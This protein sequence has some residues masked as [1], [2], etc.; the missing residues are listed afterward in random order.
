M[1]SQ[2]EAYLSPAVLANKNSIARTI[3]TISVILL[4]ASVLAGVVTAFD[5]NWDAAR[6]LAILILPLIATLWLSR[7]GQAS[8]AVF[9]LA[10]SLLM[11]STILATLGQGIHDVTN[12]VYPGI[13]LVSS[14]V[15]NKRAFFM[16]TALAL[17]AIG[18]LVLGAMFGLFAPRPHAVGALSDLLIVSVILITTAFCVYLLSDNLQQ[19]LRQANEQMLER[20]QAERALRESQTRLQLIFDHAFDGISVYEENVERGDR[21]LVDCN[22]R[23]AEIAG[24]SKE[25]LLAM[26]NTL[27]IQK[28]IGNLLNRAEFLERLNQGVYMGRFSWLRP[29]GR[30]NVIE[31]AAVPRHLDDRL[32]VIGVDHDITAR[33]QAAQEREAM[34]KALEAKNSELERFTYTVS[35][36]LKSPLI[37]IAGFVG[38]LEQDALAGNVERV[39]E[40]VI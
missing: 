31:Y 27:P 35:H 33:V 40:D 23:Y 19:S 6:A 16:L 22:A 34:I 14:L 39:R 24:R 25:A 7:Q 4:I 1:A 37:T 10:V 2:I 13:L 20:Q 21:R 15:L 32:L 38:F 5:R 17:I 29:D 3:Q 36:D 28:D 9:L 12:F 8:T 11:L 26:G 30:D 18:W